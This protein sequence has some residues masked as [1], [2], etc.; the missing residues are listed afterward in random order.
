[1]WNKTF[2]RYIMMMLM[3]IANGSVYSWGI[4]KILLNENVDRKWKSLPACCSHFEFNFVLMKKKDDMNGVTKNYG[5]NF[6]D[7]TIN[8]SIIF[9]DW[10]FLTKFFYETSKSSNISIWIWN[11][12]I[13][14]WWE[15]KLAFLKF[16][17]VVFISHLRKLKCTREFLFFSSLFIVDVVF[18]LRKFLLS[19]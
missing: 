13:P 11:F 12:Y 15:T 4:M 1:M 6:I 17:F 10:N 19:M 3:K 16:T 8:F 9:I 5:Q 2:I 18:I 7:F 14:K